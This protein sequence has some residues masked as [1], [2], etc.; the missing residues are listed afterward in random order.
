M[1]S[2]ASAPADINDTIRYTMWSVFAVAEPLD[3]PDGAPAE[4]TWA[5]KPDVYHALQAT[6]VPR[7][8]LAPTFAAALSEAA[9]R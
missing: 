2:P 9:G 7:L 3:D 4:G 1:T 6:L 5:G 8:P